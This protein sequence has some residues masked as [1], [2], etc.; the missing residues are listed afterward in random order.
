MPIARLAEDRQKRNKY[1]QQK[2]LETLALA[3]PDQPALLKVIHFSIFHLDHLILH[4][5]IYLSDIIRPN[6]ECTVFHSQNNSEDVKK[7]L[8]RII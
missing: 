5:H 1:L 6:H 3:P 8:L 2:V 7:C 4:I